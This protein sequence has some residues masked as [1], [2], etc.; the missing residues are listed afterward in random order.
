V[1]SIVAKFTGR[2]EALLGTAAAGCPIS[3]AF[4]A[5]EVG[6]FDRAKPKGRA[7]PD[8]SPL[9]R[10]CVLCGEGFYCGRCIPPMLPIS[11]LVYPAGIS[12]KLA[13]CDP[14]W[15]LRSSKLPEPLSVLITHFS[16]VSTQ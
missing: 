14:S 9:W 8:P 4:L 16:F 7:K 1:L 13:G 2:N 3:R 5:R 10:F 11:N 15:M 6:I 12:N